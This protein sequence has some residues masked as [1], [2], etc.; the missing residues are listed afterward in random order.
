MR[1]KKIENSRRRTEGRFMVA[2]QSRGIKKALRAKAQ[3][4][5][6]QI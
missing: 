1:G 6:G 4:A 3:G 5:S 2:G